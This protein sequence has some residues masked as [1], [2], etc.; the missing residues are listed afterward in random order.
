MQLFCLIFRM[1]L[2]PTAINTHLSGRRR[3]HNVQGDAQ[4][5]AC[6]GAFSVLLMSTV[7]N[8]SRPRLSILIRAGL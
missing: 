8:K 6:L 1:L 4:L 5:A 2:I 3:N 7:T